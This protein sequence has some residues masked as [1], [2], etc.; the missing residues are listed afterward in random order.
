[1]K[2]ETASMMVSGGRL[3]IT[4]AAGIENIKDPTLNFK[5]NAEEILAVRDETISLRANANLAC[6]GKVS[7]ATVKGTIDLV[8]GRVFKE[9][10]FLPLSL[11]NELPPP[12]ASST[13]GKSGPPTLPPP[14]NKWN[15]DIAIKTKDPIRLMGNVAH[16]SVVT[17][18]KLGGT[19]EKLEF[20]GKADLQEAWVK[21]PFSRL[22]I[23]S[24]IV[25]FNKELPFDPQIHVEGESIAGS[26]MVTLMVNGRALD[27]KL[28]FTSSPSLPEGEIATLLA[29]GSTT[30]D[31]QSGDG[32]AAGRAIFFLLKSLYRKII[33][34]PPGSVE[35][36]EPPRLT[37]ELSGFSGDPKRRGVAAVY[38]FNPKWKAIGRVGDAGIFRGLLYYLIRFR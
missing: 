4:G 21:L 7:S 3:Q 28:R 23:R 22:I 5:V 6:E 13:L 17:D 8:R 1:M 9:V 15:F 38:E 12:P 25:S 33:P 10:E 35:D 2:I 20:T 29:T 11:P 32:E 19:G 36:D 30:G 34:K 37:F 26:Y 24:G 31:L 16:G 27:P 14:L 18:F